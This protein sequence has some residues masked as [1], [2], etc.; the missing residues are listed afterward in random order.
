MRGCVTIAARRRDAIAMQ[1]SGGEELYAM[2]INNDV[3][4]WAADDIDLI[5]VTSVVTSE[6]S[7]QQNA[8]Y[9]AGSFL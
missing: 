4:S 7:S 2:A 5:E 1:K 3:E 8:V 6:I 9:S